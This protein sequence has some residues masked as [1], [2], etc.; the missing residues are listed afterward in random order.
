[1]TGRK[2]TI[3]ATTILIAFLALMAMYLRTPTAP[4]SENVSPS[5][6][7]VAIP[8]ISPTPYVYVPVPMTQ[9][10]ATTQLDPSD[11][12]TER[13]VYAASYQ[14]KVEGAKAT[15]GMTITAEGP[16]ASDLVFTHRNMSE[17]LGEALSYDQ[18]L[19]AVWARYGFRRLVF[20]NT[21]GGKLIHDLR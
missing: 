20:K 3:I 18:D 17:Q 21:K 5:S 11:G 8:A 4:T 12:A 10:A 16:D 7:S 6:P 15:R 1:M 14:L 19:R 9:P 2:E 13:M